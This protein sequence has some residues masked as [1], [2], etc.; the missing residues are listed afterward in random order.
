MDQTEM[1]QKNQINYKILKR[2]T[3]QKYKLLNYTSS[4]GFKKHLKKK[5]ILSFTSSIASLILSLLQR[6][7]LSSIRRVVRNSWIVIVLKL[8]PF[9]YFQS[10]HCLTLKICLKILSYFKILFLIIFCCCF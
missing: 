7:I 9:T 5:A 2:L 3:F 1:R 6:E 10:K 4:S 8:F